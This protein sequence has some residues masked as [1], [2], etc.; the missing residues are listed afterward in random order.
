[1]SSSVPNRGSIP[2]RYEIKG[3]AIGRGGMGVVY[4]AFDTSTKRDVALKTLR[5]TVEPQALELFAKEW[6]VLANLSHPNIVDILDCGEFEDE[7]QKKPFFV[8][9]L[10]PGLTLDSL[11]RKASPR[12]TTARVVEII[13]Q[14][15][16]GLQAAHEKG[17]VHRDIK[18]SNIFVLEDDTVKIIDFGVVQLA[19]AQSIAGLKGTLPYMAP[20]QVDMKPATAASDIFSLGVVCY[21]ALTGRKPFARETEIETIKAV[22]HFVPPPVSEIN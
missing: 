4:R 11:I 17:L 15:C 8:M 9:P 7:G 14:A 1:M 22:L 19:G 3:D 12:L 20:E 5:G 13:A 16:K 18:P 21:E 10:L 2:T 6:T